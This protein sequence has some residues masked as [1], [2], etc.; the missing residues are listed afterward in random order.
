MFVS[1]S[2]TTEKKTA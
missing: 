1:N 2:Q